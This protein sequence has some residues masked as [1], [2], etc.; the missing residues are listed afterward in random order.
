MD[1]SA[2]ANE[3]TL[4][5]TEIER[6]NHTNREQAKEVDE[7][8]IKLTKLENENL[9]VKSQLENVHAT[10][11]NVMEKAVTD[12]TETLIKQ[13]ASQ[14]NTMESQITLVI[15]SLQD[16]IT[17]LMNA[18]KCA[19]PPPSSNLIVKDLDPTSTQ[20]AAVTHLDQKKSKQSYNLKS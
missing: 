2:A 5:K 10:M 20:K 13:V 1:L 7:L 14:Q 3:L 19:P 11:R 15:N 16:Q 6:L 17:L 9:E 4:V 18:L 8:K 12:V